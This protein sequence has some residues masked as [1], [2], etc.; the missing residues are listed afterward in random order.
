MSYAKGGYGLLRS[1]SPR[2]GGLI[3]AERK[4]NE[5]GQSSSKPLASMSSTEGAASK[6]RPLGRAPWLW[7]TGLFWP[8]PKT[9]HCDHQ[10]LTCLRNDNGRAVTCLR[11]TCAHL[12]KPK[13]FSQPPLCLLPQPACVHITDFR[14]TSFPQTSAAAGDRPA[15]SPATVCLALLRPS[16]WVFRR[17]PPCCFHRQRFCLSRLGT[18]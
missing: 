8:K 16:T 4:G 5:G 18:T 14:P 10:S 12:P 13:P 1:T 3:Q 11:P 17:K 7:T 9:P 15:S 6:S 2:S